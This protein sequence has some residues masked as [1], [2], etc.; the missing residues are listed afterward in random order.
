MALSVLRDGRVRLGRVWFI[1][2]RF[3]HGV[4]LLSLDEGWDE[5]Y[6]G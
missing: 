2:Y 4:C 3:G 1:D 6:Q 5:E